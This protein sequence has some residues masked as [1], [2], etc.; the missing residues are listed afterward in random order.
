MDALFVPFVNKSVI[1]CGVQ[2]LH[3]KSRG[4]VTLQSADPRDPPVIDPNYFED[5]RDFVDMIQGKRKIES[6]E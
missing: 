6:L 4:T 3:P 1:N 5:D 2:I